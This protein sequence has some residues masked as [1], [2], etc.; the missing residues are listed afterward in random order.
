[1]RYRPGLPN[2]GRVGLHKEQG[3]RK[4]ANHRLW[5]GVRRVRRAQVPVVRMGCPRSILPGTGISQTS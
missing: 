1:M 3:R 2:P 5:S 4:G